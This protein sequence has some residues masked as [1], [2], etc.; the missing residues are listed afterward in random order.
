MRAYKI[1]VFLSLSLVVVFMLT[2]CEWIQNWLNPDPGSGLSPI[3]EEDATSILDTHSAASEMYRELKEEKDPN[4]Q[5]KVLDW[6]KKCSGVREA[7]TSKDGAIWILF[8]CGMV[9]SIFP[10]SAVL[11]MQPLDTRMGACNEVTT[12]P[13]AI[14]GA[15]H[16]ATA[17]TWPGS[18]KAIAL[19][20]DTK[21]RE[22]RCEA[23]IR[24]LEAAKLGYASRICAG[25]EFTIEIM[26]T[27]HQYG[28][29]YMNT[30][31][32]ISH[33]S[34]RTGTT[35]IMTGEKVTTTGLVGYWN[36]LVRELGDI[37]A[38]IG[39]GEIGGDSNKYFMVNQRFIDNY[40]YPASL[41]YMD[42]CYSFA[43][44]ALADAFINNGAAVYLGWTETTW[45]WADVDEKSGTVFSWNGFMSKAS[46]AVLS[47]LALPNTTFSHAWNAAVVNVGGQLY[48][49]EELYPVAIHED[50][51]KDGSTRICYSG[52][53]KDGAYDDMCE[54]APISPD[55]TYNLVLKYKLRSNA[56]AFLLNASFYT[57]SS[58]HLYAIETFTNG[59]DI[60]LG[61]IETDGGEKPD[62]TDIAWDNHNRK[63][64][65]VSFERLY[66][67]DHTTAQAHL[68]G[69]NL[70]VADV[71]ALA[72]D[73]SGR[74]Y[75]ATDTGDLIVV[76][77]TTGRGTVVGSYGYES[78]GDLA[79]APT[80]ALFA[81]VKEPGQSTD[82]LVK[83]DPPT[84]KATEIG[85]TGYGDV[86][87]LFFVGDQLYGVTQENLLITVDTKTGRG[88]VVR[89]LSFSAWGAQ[90]EEK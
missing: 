34:G 40:Q 27:L 3:T 57:E 17:S 29:I 30:H 67:I 25:E 23:I 33:F 78:S 73:S 28:F 80:G 1:L 45:E 43:Y 53:D 19:S 48:S 55:R 36:Y 22:Q 26:K 18:R 7:N 35:W 83:V 41:V 9:S 52:T 87:G 72:F 4:A 13:R 6:L 21:Y 58:N 31:G 38:G 39:V 15:E 63:L 24:I 62:I 20:F 56:Q 59:R 82:I 47:Q 44:E 16:S 11:E 70:G 32:G 60:L 37:R 65:G 2:G 12:S 89:Q 69:T 74:L 79:F 71:N 46:S 10:R 75:A 64:Y 61:T 14:T 8:D 51:E 68:V 42:A 54:M 85:D 84:G 90:S 49:V 76:N 66:Q 77:R 50:D 88:A 5:K 86:F 81:T